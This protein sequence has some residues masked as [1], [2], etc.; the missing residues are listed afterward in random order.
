MLLHN[1]NK[2][3]D[4]LCIIMYNS[5]YKLMVEVGCLFYL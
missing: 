1:Y 5:Q 3:I 2:K 4:I